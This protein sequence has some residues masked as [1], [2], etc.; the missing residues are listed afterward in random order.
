MKAEEFISN[1][2][3]IVD[4]S[5]IRKMSELSKNMIKPIKKIYIHEIRLEI[6]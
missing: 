6:C 1:R 3:R 4:G 5:G 2:A